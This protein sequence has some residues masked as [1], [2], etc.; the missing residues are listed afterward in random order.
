MTAV[1]HS[2]IMMSL[3]CMQ[4]WD[5]QADD[6]WQMR[7]C[8]DCAENSFVSCV[9][10][11]GREIVKNERSFVSQISH[12]H[13]LF[14]SSI[15]SRP[16]SAERIIILSMKRADNTS[17]RIYLS[18]SSQRNKFNEHPIEQAIFTTQLFAATQQHHEYYIEDT[19]NGQW[20]P[21]GN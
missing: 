21:S 12:E 17:S 20:H 14:T 16:S 7:I 8:R 13:Q 6:S 4:K 9:K 10:G 15:P 1:K 3:F 11:E 18:S 19:T 5:E 2:T